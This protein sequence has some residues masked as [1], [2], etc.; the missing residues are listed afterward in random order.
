MEKSFR[1]ARTQIREIR[2]YL[3]PF[4]IL[5]AR[6]EHRIAEMADLFDEKV[7]ELESKF[8]RDSFSDSSASGENP[9]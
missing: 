1:D 8:L 4:D 6:L 7:G 5:L 3:R 2:S 9:S